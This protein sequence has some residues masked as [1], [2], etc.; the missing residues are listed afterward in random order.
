MLI[1]PAR[2]AALE[3]DGPTV[4]RVLPFVRRR[5]VGPFIFFDHMG[6]ASFEAGRGMDVRP[7][8][9]IGLATVT[10]L[11]EGEI[12]HR[13]S[14]GY[15]Q[16]IRPGEVNWMT[17][18]RGI[19]HSERT[20]DALRATGSTLHGIQLW[21]ALPDEHEEREPSFEH[22]DAAE[23]P[24]L[25]VDGV[26]IRLIAG[27]G[28]GRTSPVVTCSPLVYAE[29]HVSAGTSVPLPPEHRE[30]AAYIVEDGNLHVFDDGTRP[31]FHLDKDAH[32]ML[33]GGD[34]IGKRHI[35]WNFV[36][37]SK[38]RIEQAKRD[39]ARGAFPK[40]VG[41]EVEYVEMPG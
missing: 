31:A 36:S 11:F 9:H 28:W 17:A 2:P 24:E 1:I 35:W 13:D 21:V 3:L 22:Y 15:L 40:V 30:L 5:M 37:S 7:H 18:G 14:L 32:V 19:A 39:W 25:E 4:G 23:I 34:P 8:P 12:D 27:T 26:R 33:I 16:T 38:E 20:P 41:D 6:P 10:Y 29:L